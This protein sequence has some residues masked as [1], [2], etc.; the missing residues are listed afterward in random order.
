MKPNYEGC[1]GMAP[2][3]E[4][5]IG[6]APSYEGYIGMAPSYQFCDK[7]GATTHLQLSSRPS[8]QLLLHILTEA[9]GGG[10]MG[11]HGTTQPF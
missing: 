3:Y 5:C 6:M 11:R 1:I 10:V 4:G 9:G 2:N 7:R 8:P